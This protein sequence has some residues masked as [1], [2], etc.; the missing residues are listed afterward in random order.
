MILNEIHGGIGSKK[1]GKVITR[2]ITTNGIRSFTPNI[3]LSFLVYLVYVV[4]I[5]AL[6]PYYL[7]ID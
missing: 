1:I 4:I 5:K 6:S 2:G 7:D 3:S